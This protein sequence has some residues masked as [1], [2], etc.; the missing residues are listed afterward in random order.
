MFHRIALT[1]TSLLLVGAASPA[2]ADGLSGN[3]TFLSDYAF[4]GVSQSAEQ[5]AVQA[6]LEAGVDQ[7]YAGLFGSNVSNK[8]YNDGNLEIDLYAGYRDSLGDWRYDL[9]LIQYRYPGAETTTVPSNDYDT[10]EA[11][12]ALGYGVADVKYSYALSDYF[13]IDNHNPP[14]AFGGAS[15]PA[16]GDSKGSDYL[17]LNLKLALPAELELAAHVGHQRVEHYDE[18]DYSDWR[19]GLSRSFPALGGLNLGLAYVDTNADEDYFT[20]ADGSGKAVLSDGR[21]IV[22]LTK[23]F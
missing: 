7:F 18:L 15:L 16:N 17:E 1:A 23:N 20:V 22:N 9:G 10:T 4:R 19:L 5:P 21:W 14:A 8:S 12:A 3:A 6:T 2:L 13:G 11:Y